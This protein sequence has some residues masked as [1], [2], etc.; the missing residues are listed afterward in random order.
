MSN[1]LSPIIQ[2][3]ELLKIYQEDHVIVVNV[4]SGKNAKD[5]FTKKHLDKALF[6]DLNTQLAAIPDD[7]ANGGRHPLPTIERFAKLLQLIGIS[8]NSHVVVYDDKNGAN[9]AARFWWMLKS[10]GLKKVQV[11]NGGMQQAEQIG[12]PINNKIEIPK[13]VPPFKAEN[14]KLP[15]ATIQ[16]VEENSLNENYLVIDVRE[17]IRYR[18]ENE[19]IDLIAG[20]IP[21]SINMPFSTNLKENGTFLSP[22]DF[23]LKYQKTLSHYNPENIIIHCGSGVTACHSIL[24]MDYAGLEIPKLYVGSWSEWSRNNKPTAI[25]I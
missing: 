18:G 2:A 24:A 15:L 20:H 17:N 16:E 12:F 7:F 6:V 11:L 14:W 5:D 13:T 22:Q 1:T 4:S 10:V 21:G 9:A 8:E 3:E 23:K 19:P 25:E